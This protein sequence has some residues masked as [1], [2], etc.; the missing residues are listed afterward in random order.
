MVE[1]IR[2]LSP[3]KLFSFLLCS[4]LFIGAESGGKP[5]CGNKR[6]LE[7]FTQGVIKYAAIL[8]SIG[9]QTFGLK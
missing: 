7:S 3:D 4:S 5:Y 1:T 8:A 9:F 6:L 2:L